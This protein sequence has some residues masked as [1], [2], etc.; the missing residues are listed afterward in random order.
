MASSI[1]SLL[2]KSEAD[3][4]KTYNDKIASEI[5]YMI[6]ELEDKKYNFAFSDLVINPDHC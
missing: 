2:R 6:T 1:R 5:K 3:D 4:K